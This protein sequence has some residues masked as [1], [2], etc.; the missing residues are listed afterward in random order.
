MLLPALSVKQGWDPNNLLYATII[1]VT[2]FTFGLFYFRRTER[3]F[4]DIA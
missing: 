4:A 2:V 1:S 3:R